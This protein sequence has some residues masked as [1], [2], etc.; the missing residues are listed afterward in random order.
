MVREFPEGFSDDLPSVPLGREIDFGIDLIPNTRP[1]FIP[2]Y[3]ITSAE[4]KEPKE[5]LKVLLNNGFHLPWCVSM[6]CSNFF[7]A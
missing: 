3:R 2:T 4:I 6:G 5:Q 1:I 7:C